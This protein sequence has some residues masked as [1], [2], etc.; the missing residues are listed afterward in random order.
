MRFKALA[1]A[2]VALVL[3]VAAPTMASAAVTHQADLTGSVV[4]VEVDAETLNAG[5][6]A[7]VMI[8]RVGAKYS[9]PAVA[10]I[11]FVNELAVDSAGILMFSATLPGGDLDDYVLS[12]NVAGATSR[13]LASLDPAGPT[14]V[15][16][17]APGT[18]N[19]VQGGLAMTGT[20]IANGVVVIVALAMLVVGAVLFFRRRRAVEA[21]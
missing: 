18:L 16:A 15:E 17:A 12:V 8:M 21:T 4:A 7:S 6:Q 10:D 13:Y 9:A 11:V 1:A 2:A 3:V 20:N 5:Q 19:P 14:P